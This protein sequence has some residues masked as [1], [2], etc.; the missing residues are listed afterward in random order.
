[1]T[2]IESL[3]SLIHSLS[4]SEKRY[5]QLS[6]DIH[7]G[8]KAYLQL[9]NCLDEHS[10]MDEKLTKKIAQILPEKKLEPARKYLFKVI[11]KSLRQFEND[12]DVEWRLMDLIKDS[13]ILF[14][15]GLTHLSLTQLSKA[16][17]LAVQSEKFMYF[18][19]AARQELQYLVR[20]QFVGIDEKQLVEKQERIRELLDH[21]T[22]TSQHAV[23]YE[24]L[25]LRYLKN[26]VARS[27]KDVNT[28]NDLL[29]EESQIVNGQRYNSFDS[30][31]LHLQFQSIYFQMTADPEGSLKIFYELDTLF[32]TNKHLW[33][34]TPIYYIH[35]LDGILNDLRFM[36]R[37][38]DMPFFIDRLA[39]TKTTTEGLDKM[40]KY[41]VLEHSI[42]SLIDQRKIQ[43]AIHLHNENA[44][45]AARDFTQLSFQMTNQLKFTF[46]RMWFIAGNYS[47]AN[48]LIN[49]VLNQPH[50]LIS[51]SLLL[52][53]NLMSLMINASSDNP[54]YLS[55]AVRSIERKLRATR[56]LY[57]VEELLLEA[58]KK[59]M[60]NKP[61]E[62]LTERFKAIEINP[63][64]RQLILELN[65][66]EWATNL[67]Q[68]KHKL[69][70]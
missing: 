51:P 46:A 7:Q 48:R 8:E 1:M 9:F 11:M 20:G 35:L 23:L 24:V 4:K 45:T 34:D 16:K 64:E 17:E 26:G 27:Y 52:A 37:F 22:H 21:E 53:S 29:L 33:I 57:G 66:H 31:Q 70:I 69:T 3:F 30:K 58:L 68:R 43:E 18:I 54:D 56:A 32:K 36:G 6:A 41:K 65:L 50:K 19:L 63:F 61:L 5:F 59:W 38:A 25:L 15:K 2:S 62:N 47:A 49:Q 55:Y 39:E 12:K 42:N 13:R 40:I 14:D 10:I 67:F 60:A 44:D 28:L